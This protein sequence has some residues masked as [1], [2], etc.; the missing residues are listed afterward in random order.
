MYVQC[1]TKRISKLQ[2]PPFAI[3]D[4]A[5]GIDFG[6]QAYCHNC[7]EKTALLFKYNLK[8]SKVNR[9]EIHQNLF[10]ILYNPFQFK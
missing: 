7:K 6:N 4:H 5:A 10:T 8:W 1:N 2:L 3:S 9:A